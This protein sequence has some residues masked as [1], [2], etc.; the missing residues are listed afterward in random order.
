MKLGG[1]GRGGGKPCQT[2]EKAGSFLKYATAKGE[3]WVTNMTVWPGDALLWDAQPWGHACFA[4]Q[5]LGSVL[6][7]TIAL[8][9]PLLPFPHLLSLELK[10]NQ[11][12]RGAILEGAISHFQTAFHAA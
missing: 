2:T 8:A 3:E 11:K 9:G 10:V 4:A 12:R 1:P 5:L 7:G 6:C